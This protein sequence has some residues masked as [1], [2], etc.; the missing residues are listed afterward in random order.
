MEIYNEFSK[1][2]YLFIGAGTTGTLVGCARFFKKYSPNTKIVAVD[3][4]GSV[5]FGFPPST[6][7][8]PGIGTSRK[9]EIASTDN[10][11]KVILVPEEET[12]VTCN[13]LLK[14]YGLFLGGSTGTVLFAARD[15]V[16]SLSN[17]NISLVAISPD[18][19]EKYLNTIYNAEWVEDKFGSAVKQRAFI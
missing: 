4:K 10:V 13:L 12:V 17:K 7:Y 3:N 6:R 8:I 19:G 9:P 2:D 15:Y 5:T 16:N 18:F 11:Y 1:L 14:K